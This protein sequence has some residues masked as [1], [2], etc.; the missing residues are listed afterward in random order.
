MAKFTALL[1]RLE[2]EPIVKRFAS[3]GTLLAL[4]TLA[5]GL[6]WIDRGTSVALTAFLVACGVPVTASARSQ[7]YG[8]VTFKRAT[9]PNTHPEIPAEYHGTN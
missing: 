5:E 3:L 7:V 4:V 1:A 9:N 8:P 2:N 6:H